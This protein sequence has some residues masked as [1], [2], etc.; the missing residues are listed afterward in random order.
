MHL[1]QRSIW[2]RNAEREA[3]SAKR[4]AQ[5]AKKFRICVPRFAFCVPRSA[6]RAPRRGVVLLLVLMILVVLTLSAYRYSELMTGEAR[7]A[8]SIARSVEAQALADS[9]I[10]YA[11][12]L[13]SN[14]STFSSVLN[15][16]PWDNAEVFQ[17]ILVQPHDV[18]KLRGRFSIV[19][20]PGPDEAPSGSLAFH[21]GVTDEGGKINLN[22][23]MIIDPTGN[24]LHDMLMTLPN[25]TPDVADAIVDWLDADNNPRPY[26]AEDDYYM[27]LSPPYHCKNGPLDSLEELLLVR[28]VTPDLL[29]G[30]DRNRNGAL[31]PGEDAGTGIFDRGWSAYLTI[32]SR[33]Q[34][35]DS[36]YN[37]RIYVNSS[38]V[39]SVYDDLVTAVGADLAY[40]IAAYRLY[41]PVANPAQQQAQAAALAALN[42]QNTNDSSDSNSSNQSSSTSNNNQTNNK[43]NTSNSSSNSSKKSS[44][45]SSQAG[46][47]TTATQGQRDDLDFT[48][49][50]VKSIASLYELIGTGVNIPN[51]QKGMSHYECPLNDPDTMR[52]L[53]P[54]LIDTATTN[55]NLE[56]PARIN[57]NTAPAAVLAA[58]PGLRNNPDLLQIILENRPTPWTNPNPDPI[59]QTPA[60]LITEANL[61]PILVQQF[62]KYITTRSQTYRLQSVGYFDSGPLS[63]RVEAVIDTNGG[64]PRIV[65]RRDLSDLQKGFNI[66]R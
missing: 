28:G 46:Q 11:A 66:P 14:T 65:Y 41:G 4:G 21:Y 54:L 36:Q 38:D 10:S 22:S 45:S 34:N 32:Y 40:Y 30:D 2:A 58:L 43:T 25:M 50:P 5:C 47:T 42:G 60:W 49:K 18:P 8:D 31:D 57:L 29:F 27:S 63:A 7:T 12:A 6:L 51:Q 56:L 16:A 23:L 33:E 52:Q 20:P 62:E 9:G 59:Y 61:P 24:V 64:R 39:K 13:L 37:P 44:S 3:R 26:G 19:S 15:N 1:H 35:Y 48:K 17:G 55:P 53:L